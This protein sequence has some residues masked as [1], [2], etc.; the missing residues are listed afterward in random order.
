[1]TRV[2][3]VVDGVIAGVVLA[4]LLLATLGREPTGDD[5]PLDAL[6]YGLI[7]VIAVATFFRRRWPR[8]VMVAC[9]ATIFGYY[10]LGFPSVGLELPLA[11]PVYTVAATGRWKL[12]TVWAFGVSAFAYVSRVL[13]GQD[14]LLLMGLQVPTT[15]AVFC[16]AIALG[17][18]VRTRRELRAE[19]ERTLAAVRR[20]AEQ[21]TAQ[22]L[23][24][25]R[26]HLARDLHDVLG[27]TVS[28]VSLHASV[29]EEALLAGEPEPALAATRAIHEASG[30]AMR[31]LRGTVQVLRGDTP[32]SLDPVGGVESIEGLVDRARKAGI[33]V[34]YT[35]EVELSAVPATAGMTAYRVVQE[36]LTNVLRHADAHHAWVRVTS[37]PGALLVRVDDDG[38][39]PRGGSGTGLR[40]MAERVELVGG[41]VRS[42]ARDQAPGFRV[43][44]RI[45]T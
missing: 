31:D 21:S 13:L 2:R 5:R 9:T 38:S 18:A 15:L 23:A 33:D 42:G 40:G 36:A 19:Q 32:E 8:T 4:V 22:R 1:M 39:G 14:P 24:A 35:L 34:T 12:A 6:G 11:A 17:D 7:A 27:H 43:W 25:E 44:A 20:E 28:V 3:P 30:A 16:G 41:S 29:A 26:V 10:M 37:E 45:P